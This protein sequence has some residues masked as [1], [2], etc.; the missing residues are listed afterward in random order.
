MADYSRE[1]MK[2]F[3]C[4][5]VSRVGVLSERT[6]QGE[7]W[8]LEVNW[9]SWNSKA[10]KLDIRS[11]DKKTHTRMTKGVTLTRSEAEALANYIRGLNDNR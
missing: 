7:P 3:K 8:T 9:I 5:I 10:P 11:W 6:I 4:N 1:E 2:N